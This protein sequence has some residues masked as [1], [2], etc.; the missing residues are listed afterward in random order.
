MESR[1]LLAG[2]LRE[3]ASKIRWRRMG[4]VSRLE[5]RLLISQVRTSPLLSCTRGPNLILLPPSHSPHHSPPS[6]T[7]LFSFTNARSFSSWLATIISL[8]VCPRHRT[9]ATSSLYSFPIAAASSSFLST[10]RVLFVLSSPEYFHFSLSLSLSPCGT[11]PHL[12][13]ASTEIGKQW[14]KHHF[15]K[16]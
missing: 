11:L 14:K 6:L 7:S 10:L 3:S 2:R 15:T 16:L 13:Y 4:R 12:I 1:R 8:V 5:G 9:Q